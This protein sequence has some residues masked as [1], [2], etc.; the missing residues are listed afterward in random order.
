MP[1]VRG[2]FPD[3][4]EDA[5]AVAGTRLHKPGVAG[6]SPAAA[7]AI[8]DCVIDHCPSEEYHARPEVSCSQL[9]ELAHSPVA[10]YLR[11]VAGI[12]PPK[13]SD[14]LS[15][16]SLLHLWAEIGEEEFWGRVAVAPENVLTATGQF[17]K[18]AKEWQAS[19]PASVIPL[20]PSDREKLWHQTR[21]ILAN[22]AARAAIELSVDRE[23]NIRWSWQGHACRCRVDG[24]TEQYFYDFK[25]TRDENP[26][27]TFWS[28]VRSFGY[29]LQ[30]AMYAAAAVAAGWPPHRMVFIITSTAWPY[31]CHVA[32]LPEAVI[33][34]GRR[35]CLAL[36]Q[37]LQTRREWD[38]WT[39]AE[40][41]EIHELYCPRFML[42]EGSDE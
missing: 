13:S 7:S 27:A 2:S 25:T 12:A 38:S 28:S 35:R 40:Y 42:E 32:R 21:Q 20:S 16:G 37:E 29:D 23:F 33:A 24:A 36:L 22:D 14:A 8:S 6:S 31:H 4:A 11:Y 3:A 5:L 1:A 19:L 41:G 30:A 10:F 15:F 26:K 18:A 9:K 17:G 34:R 39:P